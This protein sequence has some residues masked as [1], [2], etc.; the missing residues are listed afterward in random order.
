MAK[1]I[2]ACRF[3]RD[4]CDLSTY[5]LVD[6]ALFLLILLPYNINLRTVLTYKIYFPQRITVKSTF[7]L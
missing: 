6:N 4:P 7:L 1:K 2:A 5:A 3:Y